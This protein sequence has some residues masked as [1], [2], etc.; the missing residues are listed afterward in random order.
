MLSIKELR[1]RAVIRPIK[2]AVE[3]QLLDLPGVTAVDIGQRRVAGRGTGEQ[4]IVVSVRRKRPAEQLASDARVPDDVLDI[5]VDVIQEE[6]V[7]HHAHRF[8]GAQA[9]FPGARAGFPEG[10]AGFAEPAAP[11]R[12]HPRQRQNSQRG[13]EHDHCREIGEVVG[14]TGIAPSRRIAVVPPVVEVAGEYRRV[15]TLGAVVTGHAPAAV[16]MGLTTFD[17]ACMD[18]AWSVGDRMLE[19]GGGHVYADL[20]RA[21]LSGRVDAAAV[22]LGGELSHSCAVAG[23]GL[24]TGQS[25]AYPGEVVRKC[26]YGTGISSGVVASADVTLQL[27]HGDAL[28]VRVL[29]E[30]LRVESTCPSVPF[31]GYGDAGAAVVNAEGRVVG[32]HVAGNRDGTAGFACPIGDVLAELDVELGLGSSELSV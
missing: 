25:A 15:G 17:V 8:P 27:D 19:P 18:D 22:T 7:L 9:D 21:A 4:A 26:G 23:I 16:R 5:P 28:G 11:A 1:D 24:V 3:D 31:A 6:P 13:A 2:Q 30:Q 20:T 10:Q 14:G 32:L 12:R 29:R